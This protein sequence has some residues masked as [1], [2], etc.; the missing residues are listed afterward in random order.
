MLVHEIDNENATRNYA[1]QHNDQTYNYAGIQEK[2]HN[3]LNEV[4]A[5]M[6][7]IHAYIFSMVDH[8]LMHANCQG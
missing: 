3:I 7:N 8:S 4:Y 6:P 5:H 2:F 1:V